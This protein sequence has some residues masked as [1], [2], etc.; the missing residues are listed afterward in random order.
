[1]VNMAESD[2]IVRVRLANVSDL[3]ASE[4]KY[5]L[6][7]WVT[8]QRKITAGRLPQ[9]TRQQLLARKMRSS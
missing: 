2:V 5:H 4:E 1:M 9:F 7:C 8:F 6:E 3:V